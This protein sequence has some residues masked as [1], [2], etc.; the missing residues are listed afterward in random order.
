[1]FTARYELNLESLEGSAASTR[2]FCT[3]QGKLSIALTKIL[4]ILQSSKAKKK[5]N[6]T[7]FKGLKDRQRPNFSHEYDHIYI[8]I[9][10]YIPNSVLSYNRSQKR[11][12]TWAKRVIVK[13]KATERHLKKLNDYFQ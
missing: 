13:F 12:S 8:Y 2:E 1:M 10:M 6:P 4:D 3:T 11:N 9:Y 5:K 7:T